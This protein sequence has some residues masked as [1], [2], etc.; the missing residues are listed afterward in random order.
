MA[1]KIKIENI[2]IGPNANSMRVDVRFTGK[3]EVEG[4]G[5][6]KKR[7]VHANETHY[8]V[9]GLNQVE[10]TRYTHTMPVA[11]KTELRDVLTMVKGNIKDYL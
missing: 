11:W 3:I 4:T 7:D 10:E 5:G 9:D 8:F 1:A 2:R 6:K